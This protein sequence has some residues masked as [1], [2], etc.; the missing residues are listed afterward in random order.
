MTPEQILAYE[1]RVLTQE[2]REFYFSEG[3][4][5]LPGFVDAA[6]VKRLQDTTER[7]VELSR[8][9][10]EPGNVF[11]IAPEHTAEKPVLRRLKRPDERDEVYWAFARDVLADVAADLLGPDVVFHPVS[12]THLTLPTRSYV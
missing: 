11:D 4:L 1:P 3:Y 2:Q 9:E 6:T 5:G 12:Y 10:T 8:P 7:W